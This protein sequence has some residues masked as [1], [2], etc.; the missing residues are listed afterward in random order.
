MVA[1]GG[2]SSAGLFEPEEFRDG[3]HLPAAGTASSVADAA[4]EQL[5]VWAAAFGG[6]TLAAA[7]TFVDPGGGAGSAGRQRGQR[8]RG[9]SGGGPAIAVGRLAARGATEASGPAGAQRGAAALRSGR[10]RRFCGSA[11]RQAAYRDRRA[12]SRPT[13]AP[14]PALPPRTSRTSTGV[15]ECPGCGQR[16]A[17]ERRCPDCQL[18]ARRIGDGGSCTGC[19]EV[20]TVTELLGLE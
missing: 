8:C 19:G 15:Y 14:L 7:G 3:E 12:A 18:F 11:C 17:A 5:T 20:L 1:A 13:A 16:L 4:G 2:D 9:G 6:E 10:S